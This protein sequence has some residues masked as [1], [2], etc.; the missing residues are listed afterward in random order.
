MTAEEKALPMLRVAID[1]GGTFTD[2]I[3]VDDHGRMRMHK[4]PTSHLD[5]AAAIMDGLEEMAGLWGLEL[6]TFLGRTRQIVHGTT[7]ALNALLQRQGVPT[8]LLTTEGFRDALEIRR[9]RLPEQWDLRAELPPPL[10]PR[11]LRLG[12]RERLN[13]R[14]EVLTPLNDRQLEETARKLTA[15]GVEAV[16]ICFLFAFKNPVH[17]ERVARRLARLLPH[18]FISRSSDIAPVIREYERTSTTVLNAYLTPG[19]NDYLRQLEK[20]L[21]AENWHRPIHL[22]VNSGGLAHGKH[23][24]KR[25]VKVLLSGPSGGVKG[26]ETLARTW[27]R[28]NLILADMGGASF[29]VSLVVNGS[30]RLVPEAEIAGY[31]VALPLMDINSVGAGGGSIAMVDESG[32]LGIGPQS[33]GSRPGPAC[34]GTGGEAATVTDAV[35]VLGLLNPDRF[36]DGNI[37]LDTE[38]AKAAV[39]QHIARPLGLSVEEAA[40]AVFRITAA[41]MAD[42]VRLVTVQ[43]GLDPRQFSLVAAEG[44]FPLFAGLIADELEIAEIIIPYTAPAFCAWG[45]LGASRQVDKV[46]SCLV[47][48]DQWDLERITALMDQTVNAGF[49]ELEEMGVCPGRGRV[50]SLW[51]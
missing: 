12:V 24:K 43:Q 9:S 7:L 13:Y 34:Y 50:N 11:R 39:D 20:K 17:E 8:A 23:V 32:R 1:T 15:S 3:A 30:T 21:G 45:M 2:L 42:A 44:A 28:P 37:H 49:R 22:M 51:R 38:A 10:V 27:Q 46:R 5:P 19:F 6:E 26:G 40:L 29:D 18:V 36:M 4:A 47:S 48:S 33:A 41:K 14:G 31:P 25:A 35:L 16:A